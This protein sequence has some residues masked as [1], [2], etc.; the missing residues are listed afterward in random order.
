MEETSIVEPENAE[1]ESEMDT[2]YDTNQ[3]KYRTEG[4]P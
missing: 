2:K 4:M 3:V 1:Q